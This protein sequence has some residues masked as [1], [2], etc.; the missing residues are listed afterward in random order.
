MYRILDVLNP[1]LPKNKPRYI[2]G[3]GTPEDLIE[4]IYR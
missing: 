4:C 2:M 3:I 1:E